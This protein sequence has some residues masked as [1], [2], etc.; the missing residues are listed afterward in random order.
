MWSYPFLNFACQS[1]ANLRNFVCLGG[2]GGGGVI[3]GRGF[4]TSAET[5]RDQQEKSLMQP[6]RAKLYLLIE[7]YQTQFVRKRRE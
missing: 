5:M 6:T 7:I 3:G 1:V 4:R 2:G